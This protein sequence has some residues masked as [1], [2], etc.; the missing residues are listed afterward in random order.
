[1]YNSRIARRVQN[2]KSV[3]AKLPAD[4]QAQGSIPTYDLST[5]SRWKVGM[6]KPNISKRNDAL[7]FITAEAIT[8]S[9]Q[10][11]TEVAGA[12]AVVKSRLDHGPP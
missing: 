8:T 12:Q 7:A 2:F 9:T 1:M 3:L 10:N 11:G 5:G 6:R 4:I